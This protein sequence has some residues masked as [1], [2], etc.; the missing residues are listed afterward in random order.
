MVNS[1]EISHLLYVSLRKPLN[2]VGNQPKFQEPLRYW[3]EPLSIPSS[4]A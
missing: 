1:V 3:K 4:H 2:G